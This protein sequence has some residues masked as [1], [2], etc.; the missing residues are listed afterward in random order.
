MVEDHN[1]AWEADRARMLGVAAFVW[2]A[3]ERVG[4][5]AGI[6]VVALALFMLGAAVRDVAR[7]VWNIDDGDALVAELKNTTKAV[8]GVS[9]ASGKPQ[10]PVYD[11]LAAAVRAQTD[12]I[13][14]QAAL[15][16]RQRDAERF[17]R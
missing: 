11:P 8:E 13:E 7:A 4:R 6:W 15:N 16:R 9:A 1:A 5:V 3:V 14:R 2:A 12:A 10:L 17:G